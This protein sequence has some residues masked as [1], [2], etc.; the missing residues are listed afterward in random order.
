MV[1][2]TGKKLLALFYY[3]SVFLKFQH[4]FGSQFPFEVRP[5]N[6]RK[7]RRPFPELSEFHEGQEPL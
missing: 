7:Y 5:L 3:T 4:G 2:N 1:S 6:R